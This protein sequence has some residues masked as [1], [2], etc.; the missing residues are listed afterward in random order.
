MFQTKIT[1]LFG[2]KY[3]IV[4]GGMQWLSN[5]GLVAAISNAG[6][7]G[8]IASAS[9]PTPQ[10][11]REEIKKTKALTDKPFGVNINLFPTMRPLNTEEYIETL[12][13][14]GVGIVETSGRSPEAHMEQFKKGGVRVV[15]KVARIRDALSAERAGVD[16][17]TIVG[18][19]AGGHPG[20]DDVTTMVLVP[21][22]VDSLKVPLMCG[23]G[24]G[25]AR[26]FVAALALGAEGVVMGTRFLASRECWAHDNVKE[27]MVAAK[28]TD[29]MV[30]ERSI[31]NAGRYMRTKPAED[32]LA[33]E[34]KG[35]TLEELMPHI[36]GLLTKDAYTSGDLDAGVISCGQVVGL[37][38]DVPTVQEIISGIIGEAEV[39]LKRLHSA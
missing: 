1:E 14:E 18:F 32:V 13:D 8:I 30:I 11:L 35:T 20:M 37:V 7:C 33:M 24:I 16:A 19:E 29:T 15:H 38:R 6:G 10:E 36:S 9:L 28:E 5:A 21:Q 25:D 2:I 12:I 39:L 3:P 22:A 27:W 34:E 31:K 23:G 4:G 26:G 17:I